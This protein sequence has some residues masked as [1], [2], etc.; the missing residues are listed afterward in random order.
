VDLDGGAIRLLTPAQAQ[1]VPYSL[2]YS[3]DGQFLAVSS[4]ESGAGE[5]VAI[6][7]AAGQVLR[8]LPGAQVGPW[9]PT[10]HTLAVSGLA[11]VSLLAEP[12]VPGAKPQ[13][14]GPAGCT[15][16]VWKR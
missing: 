8:W 13:A 4:F 7:S 11:G 3:T 12:D 5:G 1:M 10:G 16:L 9:S 15:G 2:A 6:Y 14:V